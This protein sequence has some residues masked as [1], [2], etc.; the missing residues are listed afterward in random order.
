MMRGQHDH[1]AERVVVSDL[2]LRDF[3]QEGNLLSQAIRG[4]ILE[5]VLKQGFI[6]YS[7]GTANPEIKIFGRQ[8]ARG[9]Q[10]VEMA[11]RWL[12]ERGHEDHRRS[13]ILGRARPFRRKKL[14]V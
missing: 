6:L 14:H 7:A 5:E 4:D 12:D 2:L 13:T 3:A 1:A 11:F 8:D 9:P 10:E